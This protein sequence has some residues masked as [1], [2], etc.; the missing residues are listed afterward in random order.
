MAD[1]GRGSVWIALLCLSALGGCVSGEGRSSAVR[2]SETAAS[3]A[4]GQDCRFVT[5]AEA[6]ASAGIPNVTHEGVRLVPQPAP[7]TDPNDAIAVRANIPR[8][9]QPP[10]TESQRR[11]L[12]C[13]Y[14]FDLANE[15]MT[16]VLFVPSGYDPSRRYPLIVNLHGAGVQPLQ[17]MLFDGAADFAERD[18]YIMVAP[19]GYSTMGGWGPLR[20]TPKIVET[21]DVNP[22]TGLRF[23]VHELSEADALAVLDR[24]R[25]LYSIDENRIY[26]TGHSMG[27]FGTFFLGA[28]HNRIWAGIAPIAGGGIGPNAPA[29]ALKAIPVLILH[30]SDD[31]VVSANTSRRAAMELQKVGGQHIYLE[32]PG[33]DHEFWIRR[34]RENLEKVFQFFNTVAKSTNRGP[35][36]DDMI[37]PPAARN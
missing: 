37:A 21:A 7:S 35:I 33:R 36:T 18:G 16:Y 10:L 22:A 3:I 31:V 24:I 15:P 6:A 32:F 2:T 9:A 4:R 17:Q 1:L 12:V 11:L 8:S 19:M 23:A 14:D 34:G 26:L 29:E 27:A 25:S 20:G 5:E 13:S 30:G 28:K